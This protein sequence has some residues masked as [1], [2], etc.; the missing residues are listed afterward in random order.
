[1]LCTVDAQGSF[2]KY[3]GF[4]LVKANRQEAESA[5]GR[6]LQGDLDYCLAGKA[7]LE[8]LGASAAVITRG[9]E[10]LSLVSRTGGCQHLAAANR[11]EVFDV[12]GAGDT[13]VAVATLAWLAGAS[14][15]QAAQLAN[16]AAGL[17][18]RKLGNGTASPDEL[19]LA[20]AAM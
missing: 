19:A 2:D 10:G 12:T 16:V 9:A 18:V 5:L 3:R 8:R 7:L 20:I 6:A 11:S 13:I 17:V 14:P 1:L 4:D 15:L